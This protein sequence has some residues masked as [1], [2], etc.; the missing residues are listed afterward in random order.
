MT[1]NDFIKNLKSDIWKQSLNDVEKNPYDHLNYKLFIEDADILLDSFSSFY[2]KYNLKYHIEDESLNKCMWM[3]HVHAL[4]LIEDCIFL[5]KYKKHIIVGKMFRDI[6]EILDMAFLIRHE[7]KYL[8]MW[9]NDKVIQHSEYRK[10]IKRKKGKWLE[11]KERDE[12]KFLSGFSHNNYYQIKNSYTL[13]VGNKLVHEIHAPE[14]L[15]PQQTISQ[16]CWK[17]SFLIKKFIREML[18]SELFL[19][20]DFNKFVK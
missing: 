18:D 7:Q 10:F 12:Y 15:T 9:Y 13:G 3:L 4:C 11:S 2:D 1:E 5:L 19:E 6:T 20:E 14:I 17:L 8:N 16:Y